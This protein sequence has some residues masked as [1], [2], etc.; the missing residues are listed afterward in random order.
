M[1]LSEQKGIVFK[2]RKRERTNLFIFVTEGFRTGKK[3]CDS[4]QMQEEK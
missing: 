2:D 1:S 3:T 4:T